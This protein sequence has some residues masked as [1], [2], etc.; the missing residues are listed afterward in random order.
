MASEI[1][2]QTQLQADAR[3]IGYDK[4]LRMRATLRDVYVNRQGLYNA[5]T[6][7]IPN[8]AYM[9]VEEQSGA[10]KIRLYLKV[11]LS[12][13]VVT[14]NDRLIG[15]EV[16]PTVKTATLY[17]NNYKFAVAV[18]NYNTRYLEQKEIGL[19]DAHV[20]ELGDHAAQ[21]EGLGIRQAL[22]RTYDD[23]M[24][25]GDLSGLTQLWN[26]HAF[27]QGVTDANQPAYDYTAATYLEALGD[28]INAATEPSFR[29]LN[30]LAL[31]ALSKLLDPMTIEGEDAFI[32]AVGPGVASM[33]SDPTF[34]SGT[35]QSLGGIWQNTANLSEKVQSWY[36][37]LGKFRSAIGVSIYIVVD[38]K[39][40]V[41]DLGGSD[42]SWSLTPKY[43]L[44]GDVDQRTGTNLFDVSVLLGKNA[45][46]KWETEKLSYKTHQDDYG[47]I[48]GHGYVGSRGIQLCRYDQ[49][50]PNDTSNEYYGSMLVFTKRTVDYV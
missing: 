42:G 20:K 8:E 37:I 50:S 38:Q 29:M 13:S 10:E 30:R 35:T 23:S 22:L 47:R 40:P 39:A 9:R 24:I 28:A 14:G 45:V 31:R 33:L 12:G 11:P 34:G 19:F 7:S 6:Q 16:S 48:S 25:A 32:L 46:A 3:Q 36:G 17:R 1:S 26:P 41:V 5:K 4:K 44:P 15:S 27:V 49:A 18:E 43:V 21:Q 2:G